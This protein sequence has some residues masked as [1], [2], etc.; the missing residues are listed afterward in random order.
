MGR[1]EGSDAYVGSS[2]ETPE[3]DVTVD[4]FLL[5]T[6]EV[7]VGRFRRFVE[8]YDGTPPDAGAGSHPL[9]AG[10][11]W[12]SEWNA[13]LP[14]S[15]EALIVNIK[16]ETSNWTDLPGSNELHPIDCVNWYEAFA[17][18]IWDG[19]RL[20][21]EAEWDYAA[22][23]GIENRL[24]PWGQ[25]APDGTLAVY[26]CQW[27]GTPGECSLND[28]PPVGST[29]AGAGR[30]GHHDLGGNVWEWVLDYYDAAWY[31]GVG[32]VC[33]NC[34]NLFVAANRSSR[35]MSYGTTVDSYLR[36]AARYSWLPADRFVHVGFRC[37]RT[38]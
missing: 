17:F 7:T 11:G 1:G 30:W 14:A 22:A 13:A 25:Q 29:P 9:I 3:H 28:R 26:N 34:A 16:C 35:G 32:H 12:Q 21:T 4:A 27:G 31:G 20:P 8:Q 10:S 5:G 37:A 24:Y 33:S 6:F 18:C 19:L 23:G 15:Q 2:A 38:P 36:A